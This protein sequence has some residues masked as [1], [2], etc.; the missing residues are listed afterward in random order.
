MPTTLI[1]LDGVP[2]GLITSYA[3]KGY[4]PNIASLIAR[5]EIVQ[6]ESTIPDVSSTAWSSV[7]TGANP[8][9]HGVF[10]FFDIDRQTGR[11]CFPQFSD[12]HVSPFWEGKKAAAINIPQ[13]YPARIENGLMVSGFVSPTVEKAV[14]PAG[15]LEKVREL[16]YRIDVDSSLAQE[17]M[18]KFLDDLYAVLDSRMRLFRE[19]RDAEK[20]DIYYFVFTGTDRINHFLFDAWDD[21]SSEYHKP[22]VD[23][24]RKVDECVGEILS[25]LK[26]EEKIYIHSDHGFCPLE[27]EFYVNRWLVEK[28]YLEF[29]TDSPAL[30]T[31][32][33]PSSKAFSLDPGRIYINAKDRFPNGS[34]GT[35]DREKIKAEITEK[36][37]RL[38]SDSVCPVARVADGCEVFWGP[39][40]SRGPDLVFLGRRGIDIKSLVAVD[41]LFGKRIFRGMHTQDDAFLIAGQKENLPSPF[42]VSRIASLVV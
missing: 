7:I 37:M 3:E 36:I 9:E 14:S 16:D 41:G 26:P 30:I 24:Y 10:G 42:H 33:S 4:L 27:K 19:T 17:S 2:Y 34:V 21:E 20:W 11:L 25:T 31:D 32:M 40:S 22:F 5:G 1:G 8:G 23:Y 12:I 13:T 38:E 6:M 39:V 35:G 15:W 18:E 28:G 29:A